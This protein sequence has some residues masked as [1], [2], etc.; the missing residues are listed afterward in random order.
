MAGYAAGF[1]PGQPRP[2]VSR[3]LFRDRL[4]GAAQFGWKILQ[5]WESVFH[6]QHRL[7]VIDVNPRRELERR[8]RR[9][10]HVNEAERLMARHQVPATFFAVFS[11]AERRFLERSNVLS[12]GFDLYRIRLP[13]AESID[14]TTRPG[15]AGSAV[16]VAHRLRRASYFD[17]NSAAKAASHVTHDVRLS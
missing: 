4:A 9:R 17:F 3:A 6:R 16:A 11:L 12:P 1:R 5:L 7:G 13:Q 15:A 10:K 2:P 14:R 8:D